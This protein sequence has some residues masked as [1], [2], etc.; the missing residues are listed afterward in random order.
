MVVAGVLTTT[1]SGF[2]WA[3]P[4]KA[5]RSVWGT[6]QLGSAT[7]LQLGHAGEGVEMTG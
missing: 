6:V 5:W 2:N 3:T 4:V 7:V 1:G